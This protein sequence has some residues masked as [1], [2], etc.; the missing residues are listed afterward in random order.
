MG[1]QEQYI[2]TKADS[3]TVTQGKF[4]DLIHHKHIK[5]YGEQ[6]ADNIVRNV[7]SVYVS[8]LQQ[9][10]TQE[11]HNSL[12]VGKVQSGKTSNLELLTALAF[13]NGY[14]MLV[15]LGGYDK[16][17]LRQCTERFGKTFDSVSGD[18]FLDATTPAVFTTNEVTKESIILDSL[19]V[20]LTKLLLS[21]KRPIIITSL[22]RP[23]A[24][25]KTI[26]M[27]E[28][29]TEEVPTLRPFIIDDEGDQAS[30]NTAKDKEHDA[31]ATYA[32]I[33]H[34]KHVLHNPLYL[35]VTATPEANIFQ[36]DKSEL[37]PLSIHLIQPGIGYNGASKYHLE[38][39][40]IV[41]TVEPPTV[42][43][44]CPNSFYEAFYYFLI[45]SAIKRL[46]SNQYKEKHS[47][48][49]VHSD[50]TVKEQKKVYS[51]IVELLQEI[52][53]AFIEEQTKYYE[54]KFERSYNKYLTAD[55]REQY[56]L[57]SLLGTIR[58]VIED[59]G[60]ILQNSQGK[61]TQKK[62]QYKLHKIFVGAD[63]L[64]RGLT[65]NNLIVSYFTRFAK[66]GG[67]MDTTLQRARWFGY[68][69]KYLDLCKIFTT[70][71]IAQDF[72]NLA[73]IEDDLWDQFEEVENGSKQISDILISADNTNLK[74]TAKNKADYKKID[75]R[76]RWIKQKF[77][78]VDDELIQAN[79]TYLEKLIADVDTWTPT[80]IGS[81]H[82]DFVTAQ[83][84]E[85]TH[86]QLVD[87]ISS[88]N[89][90]FD[91]EPL[92][93]NPLLDSFGDSGA[94]VTLM[95]TP[96]EKARYR[97]IYNNSDQDRI[98]AL[99][100]GANT[101]NVEKL[102]YLGDKTVIIDPAKINIQIHHIS[103]G[104]TKDNRLGKDQ[105]MF[106]IYL[107][108]DKTYFVKDND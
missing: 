90:A 61:Q 71:T 52:K 82:N 86:E 2:M 16:N 4:F 60:V 100:Q 88:I 23:T 105:Y 68:R 42:D 69:S 81:N 37:I 78:V 11:N 5:S 96:G 28:A 104:I 91:R 95:W 73:D 79:N 64:Q 36:Y 102:R 107:P 94:I 93:R 63:L 77:I 15:I 66:N 70:D 32:A 76:H 31:T 47:D 74:P 46:R 92:Y 85:F 101:T 38:D 35:T 108:K 54:A 65:F 33:R 49:I 30:L 59:V 21:S 13:D 56:P 103:P 1:E 43:C 58:E 39:N 24:L 98:K 19:N 62:E 8:L 72:S 17:L 50:R 51:Q 89:S 97:S 7:R 29:L 75:F 55:L 10:A 18:D 57:S 87:L 20:Q 25:K 106:A 67:N 48:M 84:A 99:H 3:P 41:E 80:N 53:Q 9:L 6:G 40:T 12:L 34:M 14:N 22:K 83:Y 44:L 27:I 45:A 26:R